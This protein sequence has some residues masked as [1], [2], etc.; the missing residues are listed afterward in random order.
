MWRDGAVAAR[1]LRDL[2]FAWVVVRAQA[3]QP[4][5]I[6]RLLLPAVGCLALL[7]AMTGRPTVA[8]VAAFA[9]GGSSARPIDER[10]DVPAGTKREQNL[11]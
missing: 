1:W 9:Y 4:V 3:G 5:A 2:L 8:F 10:R 6:L 7:R 11:A